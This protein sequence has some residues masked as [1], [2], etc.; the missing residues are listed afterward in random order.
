M[1]KKEPI[2][3]SLKMAIISILVVLAI[4]GGVIYFVYSNSIEEEVQV[5]TKQGRN[6]TTNIYTTCKEVPTGND[7]EYD[8]T[9]KGALSYA[10]RDFDN[11]LIKSKEE[12]NA[13]FEGFFETNKKELD[14]EMEYYTQSTNKEY[15]PIKVELE[16]FDDE[17]FEKHNLAI[18]VGP[19]YFVSVNI[20]NGIETI[21]LR[22]IYRQG[23]LAL[24]EFF[25]F[26]TLDKDVEKVNF[27]IYGIYGDAD[28]SITDED[29]SEFITIVIGILL[30]IVVSKILL[31][32]KRKAVKAF[33]I[34]ILIVIILRV[35]FSFMIMY[36]D[37]TTV[38]K[39][40]I[41]LYPTKETEINVDLG[42]SESITSS[43]PKY[44]NGWNVKAKPNGDLIDLD[45]GKNLYALYYENESNVDF[46]VT[47]EGFCIKGEEVTEFLEE[48][49]RILGLNDK[50]AEEFIIYWLPKLEKNKYNYIRFA[51]EEEINQNMPV[52][53]TPNPDTFIRVL[54]VYKP[55]N[56]PIDLKKQELNYVQR[57][58][59]IAVE[60]GGTEI[61]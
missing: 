44:I 48:K 54:M 14:R 32:S 56:R 37:Y 15:K 59:F 10:V 21:N 24:E 16:E 17:Y 1:D 26:I 29:Y 50:E 33:M 34:I 47:D 43:Y 55:L 28:V 60:W 25:N 23:T 19:Y 40:I 41:Y 38:D 5:T 49:L 9:K 27:D 51:T 20:Q 52:E 45:T 8:V 46:K 42:K 7:I 61:H 31:K 36:F 13:Y 30:I 57:D 4:I 35:L 58:G 12:L 3:I 53:I 11:A 6:C 39:P 2:R 22:R 18:N